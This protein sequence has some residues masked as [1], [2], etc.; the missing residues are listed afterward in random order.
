MIIRSEIKQ[1]IKIKLHS[2]KK[3]SKPGINGNP[4]NWKIADVSFSLFVYLLTSFL[5]NLMR[6]TLTRIQQRP[7]NEMIL[8]DAEMADS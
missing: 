5:K 2:I 3:V 8:H 6:V 7:K 1:Q 4:Q